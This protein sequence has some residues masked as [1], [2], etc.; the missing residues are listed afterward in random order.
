MTEHVHRGLSVDELQGE[1]RDLLCLAVV[2]DH[3]R[4]VIVGDEAAELDDWLAGA[5]PQWRA[6]AD[7]VARHMVSLGVAPDGRVR[8]LAKDIPLNWVP[9][10]W[11]RSDEARRLVAYRLRTVCGWA[12][13]RRSQATDPDTVRLLD[14][15]CSS[16]EAQVRA[17]GETTRFDPTRDAEHTDPLTRPAVA[18]DR[19]QRLLVIADPRVNETA[20]CDEIVARL[21]G[22]VAVHLVV[23][24]RVSHLHFVTN[25]ES[26]EAREAEQ[27]MLIS[28]ELL[29]QR[30]V[31]TTGS[32]G[33]DKPLESMT[34]AL[35][36]FPATRVLLATPPAE[37]SYWLE[38]D[39]L[40]K[41]RALTAVA[42]TQVVVP[43]GAKP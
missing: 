8:S 9:D 15:V 28:V 39:L 6:L 36:S 21:E 33:S 20:L 42:V 13:Y 17:R 37:E 10:G 29:Q 11:L 40:V 26:E 32:V 34:D 4:W 27:S 41:A 25:D 38:R 18:V 7:Q 43:S 24:V 2:G 14:N 30:G 23:P 1:L 19:E 31:S 22:A 5:I 12:C 16:L 3:L 35:G